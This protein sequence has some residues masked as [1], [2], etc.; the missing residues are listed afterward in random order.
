MTFLEALAMTL[1]R[2]GKTEIGHDEITDTIRQVERDTMQLPLSPEYDLRNLSFMHS[3][4]RGGYSFIHPIFQEYIT[5]LWLTRNMPSFTRV[6][7][8]AYLR[9]ERIWQFIAG[10][11]QTEE[12]ALHEYFDLISSEPLG[13]LGPTYRRPVM[14][15]LNEV[16]HSIGPVA[17]V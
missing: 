10:F 7:D 11:L 9:F 1:T 15:C 5:A 2:R 17:G 4:G 8:K 12:T 14:H 6:Y 13:F 3:D 16:R